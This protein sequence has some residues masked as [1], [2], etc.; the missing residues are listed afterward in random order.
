M[1]FRVVVSEGEAVPRFYGAAYCEYQ[2]HQTICYPVPFHR[3][4]R[5]FREWWYWYRFDPVL[6]K[7]WDA[8]HLDM[9]K[10]IRQLNHEVTYLTH[11]TNDI[12]ELYEE[13]IIRCPIK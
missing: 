7:H 3:I 13:G 1:S 9:L 10:E 11:R 5:R 4:A 8:D 2:M 12:E 6:A